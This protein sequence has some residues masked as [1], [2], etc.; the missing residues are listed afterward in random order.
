MDYQDYL[1]NGEWKTYSLAHYP[2]A[3]KPV[4]L[5]L[6]LAFFAI[7]TLGMVAGYLTGYFRSCFV[8]ALIIAICLYA[9]TCPIRCPKC[10]RQVVTRIEDTKQDGQDYRQF[11]HDCPGCQIT[12]IC[13]K[14]FVSDS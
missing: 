9:K 14:T 7:M 1:K 4:Q 2:D 10:H 13:K 3:P 6:V 11:F 8:V 5:W 12:W